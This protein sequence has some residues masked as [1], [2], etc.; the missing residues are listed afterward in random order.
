M[1]EGSVLSAGCLLSMDKGSKGNGLLK[2]Y[3]SKWDDDMVSL[4]K[5]TK[6]TLAMVVGEWLFNLSIKIP[7]HKI[8]PS[9]VGFYLF[10][11]LESRQIW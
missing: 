4:S 9:F 5:H 3:F 10:S 11:P 7:D 8:P 6:V 1:K 2:R